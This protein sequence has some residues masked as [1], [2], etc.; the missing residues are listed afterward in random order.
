VINGPSSANYDEDLGTIFLS[1]WD[2]KTIFENWQTTKSGF[3]PE[4]SNVL[5]NFQNVYDCTDSTDPACLG[6]GTRFEVNFVKGTKYKIRLLNTAV[7]GWF[8]FSMDNHTFQVIATDLVPIVPFYTDSLMITVGQRYDII[9]EAN[10]TE[11]DYWMR[12]GWQNTCATN[13]AYD[14]GLG[15][16]RYNNSSTAEP[17]SVSPGF[18]DSCADADYSLFTPYVPITVGA[19]SYQNEADVGYSY[20]GLF[21]WTINNSSLYLNWSDPTT[22]KAYKNESIFPTDYN[23]YPLTVVDEW[24]YW[25]IVDDTGFMVYVLFL[26]TP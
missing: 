5:L 16:I 11:G 18:A 25:V 7:D 2:H 17:T 22:L 19:A 21:F 14:N 12:A 20:P 24:V 8:Q 15:I 4:M 9:V 13:Y 10:A 23:V 3:G 26:D 6:T 1:D